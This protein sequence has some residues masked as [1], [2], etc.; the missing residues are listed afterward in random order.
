[1][2]SFLDSYEYNFYIA[3]NDLASDI[4]DEFWNVESYTLDMAK[5]IYNCFGFICD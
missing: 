4:E 2:L 3:F 5:K 1:M